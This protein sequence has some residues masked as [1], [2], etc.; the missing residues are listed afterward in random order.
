MSLSLFIEL[1]IRI[2]KILIR[3]GI[4]VIK[5][6]PNISDKTFK[7]HFILNISSNPIR[8]NLIDLF[9]VPGCHTGIGCKGFDIIII[10]NNFYSGPYLVSPV[11]L[12]GIIKTGCICGNDRIIATQVHPSAGTNIVSDWT[13]SVA[14]VTIRHF[15]HKIAGENL[16]HSGR[17]SKFTLIRFINISIH[18]KRRFIIGFRIDYLIDFSPDYSPENRCWTVVKRNI[19]RLFCFSK[20][21]NRIIGSY[22]ISCRRSRPGICGRRMNFTIHTIH[23]QL[24]GFIQIRRQAD[25]ADI[26]RISIF[27]QRNIKHFLHLT[28]RCVETEVTQCFADK[29]NR[30]DERKITNIIGSFYISL[31]AVVITVNLLG[32][33]R[34]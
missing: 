24:C 9:S 8:K 23:G 21:C 18:L 10:Q 1:I 22:H 17:V 26:F 2:Q 15:I 32:T 6:E 31:P 12:I 3:I 34:R 5:P 19:K 20:A 7:F 14:P 25:S 30:T 16:I 27:S 13:G 33:R 4:R 11:D 28:I 29:G